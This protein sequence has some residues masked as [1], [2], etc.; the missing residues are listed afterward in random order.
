VGGRSGRLRIPDA[1]SVSLLVRA[2]H[3]VLA[4]EVRFDVCRSCVDSVCV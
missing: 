1:V 3:V 2:G 4:R